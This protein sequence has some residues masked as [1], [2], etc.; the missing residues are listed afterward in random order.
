MTKEEKKLWYDFLTKLPYTI[1]RQE[2]IDN[3]IVDFY[4]DKT[5]TVI[6]IDGAQH[7][8]EQ[9][10]EKDI[11]RDSKLLSMGLTVLRYSNM[12]INKNFEGVC[13]E[14]AR[15]FGIIQE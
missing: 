7:Y 11:M 9:G 12:D 14:I 10:V 8:E 4:C 15:H 2:I 6:E 13:A 1:K 3:Y 5:K